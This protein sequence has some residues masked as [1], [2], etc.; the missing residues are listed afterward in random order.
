MTVQR[1]EEYTEVVNYDTGNIGPVVV[2]S[3]RVETDDA[4]PYNP[5]PA[6]AYQTETVSH[7][8][9][10]ARLVQVVNIQQVI[11]LLFGIVEGLL[12]IR[13]VLGL[14]GANPAAGFAQLIYR[15]T[16]PFL[17]PFAG[18]FGQPSYEGMVFDWNALVA[19]LVYALLSG[20]L[21]KL[22]AFVMGTT[23]RDRYIR[24]TSRVNRI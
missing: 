8:P 14:L 21:A 2:N 20:L 1:R 10:A 15:I 24:T 7:D 12:G 16:D 4:E 13:F 5:A 23:Q 6:M 18:L 11:F 17:A 3:H 9:Y 19:I 22:V